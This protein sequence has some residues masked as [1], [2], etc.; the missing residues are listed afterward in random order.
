[1]VGT[2]SPTCWPQRKGRGARDWS[3]WNSWTTRFR[4]FVGWWTLWGAGRV[5][6]PE[7]AWNLSTPPPMLTLCISSIW[8]FL[9]C[10]L[11]NKLANI[12]KVFSWVLSAVLANYWIWGRSW[13]PTNLY[14]TGQKCGSLGHT[15]CSWHLKWGQSCG[16]EPLTCGVCANMVRIEF[17]CGHQLVLENWCVRILHIWCQREPQW[18]Q[19]E[20]C[21]YT[22]K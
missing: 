22:K 3:L 10:I 16:T 8:L 6:H 14:S 2:F 4:E 9:S 12:S 7:R 19:T 20:T 1:M 11:Y 15:I 18:Y 13:E 5:V 17:N 21:I